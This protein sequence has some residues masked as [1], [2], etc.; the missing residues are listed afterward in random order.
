MKKLYFLLFC[1]S[2]F[3]MA[4][5]N[6]QQYISFEA[7]EGYILGNIDGQQG[8][9]TTGLGGGVNT[10]LQVVTDAIAKTGERSLKITY[11]PQASSQPFPIMGAFYTLDTPLD[12]TDFSIRYSINVEN[13][14]GGNSSIFAL[15]C[16]S[17]VDEKLVL[18]IY[19]SYDGKILVL[20]NA[21]TEFIVTQIGTWQEDTW[22][23]VAISGNGE[24]V[25]YFLN[26]E[27]KYVGALLYNIDDLRFAHDN[28]SGSAFFDD[29]SLN[30]FTLGENDVNSLTWGLYPNPVEDYLNHDGLQDGESFAIFDIT[31]KK[32]MESNIFT[33]QIS[34]K[35]LPSGIY[36]LSINGVSGHV[37]KKFIKK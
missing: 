17:I 14:P 37:S 34:V 27:L 26:G 8:W 9:T 2:L 22:Y 3:N 32:V 23:D 25:S 20:E 35:T 7:A 4:P 29:I 21:G 33:N 36:I 18:E 31:G 5:I 1:A 28:F 12:R 19:F 30:Y 11:D 6:A 10:E 15:E 24:E 16:G 13:P